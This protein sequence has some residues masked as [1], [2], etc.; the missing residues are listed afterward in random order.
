MSVNQNECKSKLVQLEMSAI[1]IK[2]K[3]KWVQRIRSEILM[4][5][6]QN[7]YSL[8]RVRIKTSPDQNKCKS[9]ECISNRVQV[10]TTV[11]RK[12]KTDENQT[13]ENQNEFK[14]KWVQIK[15]S[16]NWNECNLKWAFIKS[17]ASHN[18]FK[19][20]LFGH[21]VG[22]T[23]ALVYQNRNF[24][25]DSFLRQFNMNHTKNSW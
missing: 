2:C 9:F 23:F 17:S 22:R 14:S 12:L 20:D 3:S 25:T 15:T 19:F 10:K 13:N 18:Q 24:S 8:K 11:N 21:P 7:E 4:S 6:N 5:A 16:A 1:K